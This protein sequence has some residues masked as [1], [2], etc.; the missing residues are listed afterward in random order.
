MHVDKMTGHELSLVKYC[1][2]CKQF[3]NQVNGTCMRRIEDDATNEE[4]LEVN[5][6]S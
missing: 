3:R 1:Y 6:S 5:L 2:P 4:V